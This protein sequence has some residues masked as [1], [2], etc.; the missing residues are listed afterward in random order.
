VPDV[1]EHGRAHRVGHSGAAGRREPPPVGDVDAPQFGRGVP[2]QF[3]FWVDQKSGIWCRA[4]LDWNPMP[5][6]SRLIIGDYKTTE[7]ASPESI[8]KSVLRYGYHI[9]AKWYTDGIKA[10]GLDQGYEPAFVFAFQEKDPPHLI[11]MV[12]LDRDWLLAAAIDIR[13]AIEKYR[14][15]TRTGI[16]PGYADDV[17]QISPPPWAIRKIL[18]EAA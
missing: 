10:L 7:S 14:E 5:S 12:E 13:D 18:G 1:R 6:G 8:I 9:Q 3:L 16:W 2:E 11:T 4:R 17:K 15:C